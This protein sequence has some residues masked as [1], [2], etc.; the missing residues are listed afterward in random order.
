MCPASVP[1]NRIKPAI[2]RKSSFQ[3]D[4]AGP[5]SQRSPVPALL[6]A[7]P[8]RNRANQNREDCEVTEREI[9]RRMKAQP[10]AFI[11]MGEMAAVT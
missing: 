5:C 3:T 1:P 8:A 4:P 11:L 6:P 7:P 2:I 9:D 10:L